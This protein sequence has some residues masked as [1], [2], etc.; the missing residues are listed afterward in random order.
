MFNV[1]PKLQERSVFREASD[2]VI[3]KITKY[4][5]PEKMMM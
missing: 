4:I 2:D 1:N 3:A 5:M